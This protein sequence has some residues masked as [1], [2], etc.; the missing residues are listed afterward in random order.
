MSTACFS[1]FVIILVFLQPFFCDQ[2]DYPILRNGRQNRDAGY[3]QQPHD[4]ISKLEEALVWAL[5]IC[6]LTEQPSHCRDD[7]LGIRV[8]LRYMYNSAVPRRLRCPVDLG[9][10]VRYL[11]RVKLG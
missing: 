8:K 4:R 2:A 11:N 9:N 10:R 3:T 1:A 5:G 7:T 6:G